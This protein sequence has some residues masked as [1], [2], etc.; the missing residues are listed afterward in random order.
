MQGLHHRIKRRD[1]DAAGDEDAMS[2]TLTQRK[3]IDWVGNGERVASV[4]ACRS[5]LV[6]NSMVMVLQLYQ[7][8]TSFGT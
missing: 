8:Y 5:S 6:P 2:R 1:A 4:K 3:S 7:L